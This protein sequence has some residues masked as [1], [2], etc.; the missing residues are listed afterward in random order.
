ML[1]AEVEEPVVSRLR[2]VT[3]GQGLGEPEVL[4]RSGFQLLWQ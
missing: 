3:L 2:L 1:P 4:P